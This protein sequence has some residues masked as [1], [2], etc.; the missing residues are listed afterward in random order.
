MKKINLTLII[1]L[2]TMFVSLSQESSITK[3]ELTDIQN[4]FTKDA[5]TLALQNAIS[6]NKLSDISLNRSEVGK[7]DNNFKYSVNVIGITNQKQSGRCWMF[8]SLNIIRPKV[9]EKYNL[10]SFEFSTN[11]LHFWDIFEK[12]NMFLERIILSANED[13][14]SRQVSKLF[15]SPVGDGGAWNTFT[16][17][18]SKYGAVPK[19]AMP[20]TYNSEHTSNYM[21]LLNVKLREDGL[22]L[23]EMIA[24]K[25]SEKEVQDK[26][27]EMLKDVYRILALSL[28]VP[29]AEFVWRYKDNNGDISE[30]AKYT[31]E[32]FW[33]D[34]VDFNVDDYIMF[35][36]DPSREYYK[37][38]E[39]ALD[40]NVAEGTNWKYINLP[41]AELKLFALK[42]IKNNDAMYFS[43][44]V[45]K[46]LNRKA[47]L[48][49]V[50]NYDYE[51]LYGVEFNM[52]KKQRMMSH[53]S[54]S[55][56]GMALVAVDTDKDDK[57]TQWRLENSWGATS[58]DHGYLT[59]TD[60]WF[61]EY[62]FRLVINKKYLDEKTL[63]I[64]EQKPT[65]VPY[66]NPAFMFDK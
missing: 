11:Y 27:I 55:S 23:R 7:Y 45:G 16:N 58:G 24:S 35:I 60:K 17:L 4:S 25:K 3:K 38:Y 59:M 46:Q 61:E 18:V 54:G 47:G 62:M 51:S 63:K 31:P 56:H 50:D 64:L 43:C 19:S 1:I 6:N 2:L 30:Y 5:Q 66:Y 26:K 52:D 20:E 8:T 36:D 12:S 53:Q 22:I 28:G 9:I 39:V 34:A 48:L 49:S 57:P 44:D 41:A 40:K 10:S 14:Y 32:T 15:D 37:L 42:S 65:K 29:P 13:I 33:K 21:K